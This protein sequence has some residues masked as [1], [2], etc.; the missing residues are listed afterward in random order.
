M[1]NTITKVVATQLV[2]NQPNTPPAKKNHSCGLWFISTFLLLF[3]SCASMLCAQ[4]NTVRIL[5]IGNSFTVDALEQHFQPILDAQGKDA[6]IGYP[7]RGGTF[8]SQHDAWST[9]TDTLPYNYRKFTH[10]QFTSTGLATYN[11]TMA[12]ADEPWDWVIIQSDHDSAGIYKSYVPYMEHLINFVHSHC[13]NPNVKIGFYMTWA[14]DATS[15]FPG[16]DLY[17]RN[18]QLMY[19]SIIACAQKLMAAHPDL[20]FIIPSGTAVQNARTSFVGQHLNRDGYH[21]HYEH[22]RYIS[23]L[24]WYEKIFGESA[25]TVTYKPDGMTDYKA[26]MC[27]T[28]AHSAIINPY[29]VTDLS[30]EYGEPDFEPIEPGTESHLKKLTLNGMNIALPD[31]QTTLTALVDYTISPVAMYAIPVDDKC[32]LNI[33]D[34]YGADIE[35]DTSRPWYYPL[36]TPANG[37]SATYTIRVIS[38]AGGGDETIYTLTITGAPASSLTYP[39]SSLEDLENFAAAVNGGSYAING[40]VT[41]DFN[42]NH[43]KQE[44][45]MTPI[46]SKDHPWTGTFD[47]LGHKITGF[48]IYSVD[49]ALLN[50][51]YV[52]LFGYIKN[53]T[54]RNLRIEGT[55]ESYFNMASGTT[56]ALTNNAYGILCGAM[57]SS[58]ISDCSVSCPIFTNVGGA[59]AMLVG[60]ND[61][62]AGTPSV[63]ERCYTSGTWRI[64]RNGI[65]GGIL[66]YSYNVVI[67]DCYSTCTLALQK[68]YAARIG[69]I[70]GYAN[71]VGGSRSVTL[72]NCHF[73]G[74]IK[75]DR[76]AQ[77]AATTQTITAGA[78]AAM[79]GGVNATATNCWF[80]T[81]SATQAFGSTNGNTPTATEGTATQFADG[82]VTAALGNAW[83]QGSKY[84]ELKAPD[85]I[86]A[87]DEISNPQSSI[88]NFQSSNNKLLR[89]GQLLIIRDGKAYSAGGHLVYK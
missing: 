85:I 4:D 51:Q 39:I 64:R 31:G 24:C 66:G 14:Y 65:Y 21:L 62:V 89:N 46:G 28:A 74:N 6:I 2:D 38:E 59:V 54:I 41:K 73:A 20:E 43:T 86:T 3:L 76:A 48:N 58:T 83:Q 57:V 75:D 44:C 16:F 45:W 84:P 50:F 53:A 19:D 27:R 17:G 7:Y 55:E 10:G 34:A 5:G 56:D 30:A 52:G 11:M 82:T 78:M 13:S 33:T 26:N 22:G 40:E 25:L 81:G 23:S 15:T 60:R 87:L 49:N 67:R 71:N 12:M 70:V 72:Q 79:F 63:I 47:G 1:K 68:N 9:R 69:G 80:L 29:E 37:A 36:V 88:F 32:E 8:L 61:N 42:C 18:Q 77:G 35:R